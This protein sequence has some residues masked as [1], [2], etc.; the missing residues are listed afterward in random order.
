M[1]EWPTDR[2][3]GSLSSYWMVSLKAESESTCSDA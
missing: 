1:S 2:L 3:G